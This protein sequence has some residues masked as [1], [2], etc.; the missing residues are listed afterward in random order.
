MGCAR[1]RFF[2]AP[3]IIFGEQVDARQGG[4]FGEGLDISGIA[5]RKNHGRGAA[6]SKENHER[7][8]QGCGQQ[9]NGRNMGALA[10]DGW[11][12]R[13]GIL[14]VTFHGRAWVEGE[15]KVYFQVNFTRVAIETLKAGKIRLRFLLNT[16]GERNGQIKNDA[17]WVWN[18]PRIIRF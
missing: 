11:I 12:G 14:Q 7:G 16:A 2:V 1:R 9:T 17:K 4:G 18:V 3:Q 15:R 8:G 10:G 13:T 5:S 6:G